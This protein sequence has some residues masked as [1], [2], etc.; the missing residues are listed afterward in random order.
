MQKQANAER[1]LTEIFGPRLLTLTHLDIHLDRSGKQR[2]RFRIHGGAILEIEIGLRAEIFSY[3]IWT[4]ID[5]TNILT[6]YDHDW[7]TPFFRNNKPI[8]IRVCI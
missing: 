8:V 1:A 7:G 6:N 2:R 4:G 5:A 3:Q